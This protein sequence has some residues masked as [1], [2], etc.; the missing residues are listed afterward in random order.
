M[1]EMVN[2]Q[3]HHAV[4]QCIK[5]SVALFHLTEHQQEVSLVVMVQFQKPIINQIFL[6][7]LVVIRLPVIGHALLAQQMYEECVN[8]IVVVPLGLTEHQQEVSLVV[9]VQLH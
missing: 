4:L 2:Q 9:M 8:Q 3:R 7:V 5:I 6:Q 1:N